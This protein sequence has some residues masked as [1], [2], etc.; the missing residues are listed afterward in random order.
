[1]K[2]SNGVEWA[3]HACALLA[4]LPEAKGLKAEA[5]AAYHELPPAYMAK[6]LQALSKAGLVKTARGAKG[7]Y[8]LGVPPAQISLWDIT[9]AIDGVSPAFRC[10]EIRQA[11][12]CPARATEC[13]TPCPIAKAFLDAETAMRDH[14]KTIRLIDICQ[15]IGANITPLKAEKFGQ[16]LST[17]MIDLTPE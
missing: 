10:S 14:L 16:W 15:E 2:L 11:G 17:A 5:I 7:G 6:Q 8:R 4:A 9:A 12:P 13:K 1:M 3:V